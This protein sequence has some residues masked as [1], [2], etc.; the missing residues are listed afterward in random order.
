MK[1]EIGDDSI[2]EWI[3]LNEKQTQ[4]FYNTIGELLCDKCGVG[5][6]VKGRFRGE[7]YLIDSIYY[8]DVVF[9]VK[10]IFEVE[11]ECENKMYLKE[12][13]K[14]ESKKFN[15]KDEYLSQN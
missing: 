11:D 2:I 5:K 3:N 8:Y 12:F 4:V 9:D 7:V 6:N 15:I 14:N 10:N 13:R 1:N